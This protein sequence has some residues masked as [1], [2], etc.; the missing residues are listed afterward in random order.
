MNPEVAARCAQARLLKL[1]RGPMSRVDAGRRAPCNQ[2][3]ILASRVRRS[4]LGGFAVVPWWAHTE[5]EEAHSIRSP[6]ELLKRISRLLH[7]PVGYQQ[8]IRL[9]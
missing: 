2:D 4:V 5:W 7:N 3:P 6:E 1:D 8:L 9:P